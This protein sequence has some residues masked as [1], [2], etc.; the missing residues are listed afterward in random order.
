MP[1]KED[2]IRVPIKDI[3]SMRIEDEMLVLKKKTKREQVFLPKFKGVSLQTW[4]QR[5]MYLDFRAKA[6]VWINETG[7]NISAAA[8]ERVEQISHAMAEDDAGNRVEK[9]L[10]S[11]NGHYEVE[12]IAIVAFG[13]AKRIEHQSGIHGWAESYTIHF[14]ESMLAPA[15]RLSPHTVERLKGKII[16]PPLS[17]PS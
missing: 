16:Q 14:I 5:H 6:Q 7:A 10:R 2:I 8:G 11:T 12:D 17:E 3:D 9:R 13:E 4:W 15:R 1:R